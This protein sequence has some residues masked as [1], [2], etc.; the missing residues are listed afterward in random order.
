MKKGLS[1]LLALLMCLTVLAGCSCT[2][3][4]TAP[5]SSAQPTASDAEKAWLRDN[6]PS[7]DGSTSLI[8]LEAGIRS[9]LFGITR[10]EATDQVEHTTTWGSFNNLVE[11]SVDLIFT[12]PLSQEQRDILAERGISLEE[13]PVAME[14]F[15]F[16]VNAQNPVDT[17]TQQQ[18]KDIYSG[19]IT[20]WKELGGNDEE[21]VAYQRNN[22]SGSQNY[23]IDFMGDTPLIDAPTE[24]RPKGMAT[25][26]DAVALSDNAANAI[27]YSV[28]AY[29]A[30]MYSNSSSVKF[31]KV[32]GVAP[33]RATIA[34]RDYPLTGYNYAMF[35]SDEPADSAARRLVAFILTDEGQHAVADA[36]YVAVNDIDYDYSVV[37]E[38]KFAGVGRGGAAPETVGTWKSVLNYYCLEDDAVTFLADK[39]LQAEVNDYIKTAWE[40][41]K[42]DTN[43]DDLWVAVS[44]QNGYFSVCV[45]RAAGEDCFIKG[46]TAVWDL[47]TGKKLSIEDLFFD[48]VPISERL[49]DYVVDCAEQSRSWGWYWQDKDYLYPYEEG[50]EPRALPETG[51]CLGVD[52]I[53]IEKMVCG[54]P[55]G[56]R[57][58]LNALPHGSMVTEIPYDM[59]AHF[60]KTAID[61]GKVQLQVKPVQMKDNIDYVRLYDDQNVQV[62]LLKEDAYPTAAAINADLMKYAKTAFSRE[63][64]ENYLSKD[65]DELFNE[66][67]SFVACDISGFEIPGKYYI[68]YSIMDF[69]F[70]NYPYDFAIRVYDLA[71]GKLVPW[72]VLLKDGW[73]SAA[74]F[75]ID[76]KEQAI[77]A[78]IGEE[79]V[80]QIDFDYFDSLDYFDY[81]VTIRFLSDET[82]KLLYIPLEYLNY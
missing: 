72:T 82:S 22:D 54:F 81:F 46:T 31:I 40:S 28:Y 64:I 51:W 62:G 59:T 77:P 12:C 52:E 15:V 5:E 33:N 27:G 71:T 69:G 37:T 41:L 7:M 55:Y 58:E 39:T 56:A 48:G 23:M 73:R 30:D 26:M 68:V 50:H 20:N 3:Q 11:G 8:P 60:D 18:I 61:E 13:I 74:R 29:A 10:E 42:K 25:L 16:V 4:E 19:K 79:A 32:D 65:E 9:A 80:D 45:G 34:T 57:I 14:A 63:A 53:Y 49:I 2:Q 21:I 24:L 78:D 43:D 67:A 35:R 36:G 44:A 17:L 6:L 70:D 38:K 47:R 75:E 1:T 66:N 76:G